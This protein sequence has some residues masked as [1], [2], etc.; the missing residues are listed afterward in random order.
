MRISTIAAVALVLLA[1]AVG[2]YLGAQ[3]TRHVEPDAWGFDSEAFATRYDCEASVPS[4]EDSGY[5]EG[6]ACEPLTFAQAHARGFDLI[7]LNRGRQ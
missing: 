7:P 2:Y 3:Q 1:G 4:K 5:R 6:A